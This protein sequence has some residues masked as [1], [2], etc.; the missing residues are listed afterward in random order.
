MLISSVKNYLYTLPL[1]YD[2]H[3]AYVT[4]M[5]LS[6]FD[7]WK[8]LHHLNDRMRNLLGAAGLLHDTGTIVNYYSHARHSA[9][10]TDNAHIFGWSL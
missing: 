1:E 7:Q 6:M 2:F 3:T 9:Y 8:K 10:I 4:A 5:A